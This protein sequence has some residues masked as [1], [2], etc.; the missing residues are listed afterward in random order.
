MGGI[1]MVIGPKDGD[2]FAL[3]GI[4]EV[5]RMQRGDINKC[6]VLPTE[7]E[8]KN[9][10]IQ[11][12]PYLNYGLASDYGESFDFVEMEMFTPQ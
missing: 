5:M 7:F 12:S 4:Y 6:W 11:E 9:L 3:A 1:K 8:V 2:E 10:I